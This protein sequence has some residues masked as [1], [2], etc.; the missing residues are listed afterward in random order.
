MLPCCSLEQLDEAVAAAADALPALAADEADRRAALLEIADRVEGARPELGAILSAETGDAG[1][2]A[3]AGGRPEEQFGPALP[4]LRYDDL[5]EAIRRANA[6]MYGL[7]GSVWNGELERAREPAAR[8]ECRV[9]YANPHGVHRPSVPMRG[10]KWSGIG[11]EHGL[12]GLL[13]LTEKQI[14][15]ATRRAGRGWPPE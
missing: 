15:Y 5:D 14:V 7:C 4:M 6:T 13:E 2:T 10:S 12:E 3:V 9:T 11:V 8:L 1:A